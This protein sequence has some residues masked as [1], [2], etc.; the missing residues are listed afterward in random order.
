M[1]A[2][3]H[4][5][6]W[7]GHQ[8]YFYCESDADASCLNYAYCG[9]DEWSEDHANLHERVPQTECLYLPWLEAED[10]TYLDLPWTEDGE[11]I[12]PRPGEIDVKWNG[13]S[14]EWSYADGGTY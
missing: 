3:K 5:V 14:Y 6:I 12:Q 8:P 11:P 4:G 10:H 7:D 1:N 13:E 2:G 9:C